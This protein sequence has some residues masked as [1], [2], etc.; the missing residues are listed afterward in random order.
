MTQIDLSSIKSGPAE[1]DRLNY[2]SPEIFELEIKNIFGKAW[3]FVAHA[4]ELKGK[5]SYRS[6]VIGGQPVVAV[7]GED[8][9]IRVFFNSCRHK[10]T[11]LV[12]ERE[13]Q[14]E[15]LKCPYHH[16]TYSTV[17]KLISVP[18]V[19]AYG[20][21]FKLQDHGL[22]EVPRV[23]V[24]HDLIFANLSEDG[25]DL[26]EFL[27]PAA[28]Y[29]VES[30]TY[31]G[32]EMVSIGAY[33]YSYAGNW[34]L[35]MEN[36]LDDYH[37]EYLHD[38]AFAQR[39]DLFDMGG[40]TGFQETEGTRWSVQLGIHGAFDQQ[41]DVRT[42]VIQKDR[43]RRV[44]VGIFPSF[45]A[46]YH[47]IWDVTG[48]RVIEPIAVDKTII[49]TYCLA[50]ASS[51][52]EERK[53]IGERFHYSWGPGGRAGVDDVMIFDRV[54]QGLQAQTAGSVLINRGLHR[55]THMGIAADDNAVRGFWEGWRKFMNVSK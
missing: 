33:E 9:E 14:V 24:F 45:I 41:D 6:C 12:C 48:L 30:A 43:P 40:T 18:R 22:I 49:R 27:G 28:E 20:E 36:T 1:V 38:Y 44:Y 34:K 11:T 21:K 8:N 17:G 46:L 19:E 54:Q 52:Q 16:W 31:S 10:G 51:S 32:A 23:E 42:L 25:P 29:L 55:D 4:S 39:A 13:G 47:P 3:L 26:T 7:R 53:A 50:P 5:G 15:K 2:T 37:A 35:M